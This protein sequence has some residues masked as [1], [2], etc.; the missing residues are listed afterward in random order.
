VRPSRRAYLDWLRGFAVICMI[1]WHVIDSWTAAGAKTGSAW[2]IIVVIGGMAAPLFL[3]LAG[4]AVPLAI[5]AYVSRGETVRQAAWMVQRRGWQVFLIAH[6]FRLQSF[7]TNPHAQWSSLLKPDIL[8][9][10][11]LGLAGTAW[12]TGRARSGKS[13][14]L[15]L[16]VPA[17]I[18]LLLTPWARVWWWPTL[19]HPRLEAYI[20]KVDGYGVFELFPWIAYVPVG[21]FMGSLIAALRD[22]TADGRLHRQFALWGLVTAAAGYGLRYLVVPQPIAW[23]IQPWSL[24]LTQAGFMTAA[25]WLSWALLRISWI[26]ST[27]GPL[28]LFGRTSLFVYWVHLELAFGLLS[29]P[30]HGALPL[31]GS[32]TGFVLMTVAMYFAATWW[33]DRPQAPWIP[34]QLTTDN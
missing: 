27:A 33:N 6:L 15:W 19:L 32:I 24:F 26:E 25:I 28:V 3:F 21:A 29:Y 17:V 4:V 22:S 7:L 20:R 8:N 23:S 5:A 34:R 13:R 14:V 18:V 11:G 2:P 16:L 31:T 12:L 1:E 10:L 30:L 9:I